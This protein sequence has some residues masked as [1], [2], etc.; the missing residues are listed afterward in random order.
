MFIDKYPQF[1]AGR[2]LK[3]EMLSLLRDYPRDYLN[4]LYGEYADGVIAGCGLTVTGDTVAIAP[5]IVRCRERLYTLRQSMALPYTATG[6]DA[7]IKIS[8]NRRKENDDYILRSGEVAIHSGLKINDGE[9]ELGRFKLKKGA[10]LRDIYQDFADMATEYDT[11]NIINVPYAVPYENTLSPLITRRFA[12]EA[13]RSRPV[14]PFDY[15]FI[16][17]CAQ[18]EP[19]SRSLITAYT[20]ARLGIVTQDSTNQD[21]HRHLVRIL[22]DI[23]QGKDMV[24]ATG[25]GGGRRILVD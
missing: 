1:T 16:S 8:F 21:M 5:G 6:Q 22:Q 12:Q 3:G 4:I 17:H 7:I 24:T 9:M 10:R 25:R 15:V 19:V 18:G 2:V 13:L 14:H 23:R 20:A 11:V